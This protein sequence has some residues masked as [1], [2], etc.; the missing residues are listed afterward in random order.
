MEI[1]LQREDGRSV[2]LVS[3]LGEV[4]GCSRNHS[5]LLNS[6]SPIEGLPPFSHFHFIADQN[7]HRNSLVL[8]RFLYFLALSGVC[9]HPSSPACGEN[10]LSIQEISPHF[11][12]SVL[13]CFEVRGSTT[14]PF[15]HSLLRTTS[16]ISLPL[17][18]TIKYS[19]E[20][21]GESRP[22]HRRC[23]WRWRQ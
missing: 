2:T 21:S 6:R 15:V 4:S 14:S 5:T 12:S 17:K 23:Q 16:D 18:S 10:Q 13:D 22:A 7:P 3:F 9:L 1:N 8:G 11:F 19:H 20:R